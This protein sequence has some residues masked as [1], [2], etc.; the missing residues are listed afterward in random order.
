MKV[1]VVGASRY[2]GA[3]LL[4]LLTA[5]PA[6]EVAVVT[7]HSHV[8]ET[9]GVHTPSL[10]AA[11]L[12]LV[13]EDHDPGRLEGLDVVFCALPHGESQRIVPQL[14]GHVGGIV[15]LAADFRLRDPG[16]YP[17]WYGEPHGAPELLAEAV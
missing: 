10:A 16:L 15:D 2:T 7:A 5:H 4:R 6:F 12:G 9:V 1:G 8:G 17:Q 14:Q 11:Y 13:Y 3:E